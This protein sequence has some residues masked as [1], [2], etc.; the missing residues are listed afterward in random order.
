MVLDPY[1]TF[2]LVTNSL[3]PIVCD[4]CNSLY[5]GDCP[6]HGPLK[7]LSS[8]ASY[9]LSSLTY[10]NLPVPAQ[11]TIRP[12]SIPNAG[13]GTFANQF[14]PRGVRLGPYEGRRVSKLDMGDIKDTQYVWEVR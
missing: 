11:L 1:S 12:S 4:D 2:L 10:T 8:S 13:L 3:S 14:I 7:Q 9:D 6:V 5:H